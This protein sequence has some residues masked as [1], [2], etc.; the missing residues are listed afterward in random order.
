MKGA[1]AVV[2]VAACTD[3]KV[4]NAVTVKV[5][6][7]CNRDAEKITAAQVEAVLSRDV[8]LLSLPDG[9]V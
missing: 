3:C 6:Y 5:A 7:V 1:A 2:S 4:G 9:A 8:Y